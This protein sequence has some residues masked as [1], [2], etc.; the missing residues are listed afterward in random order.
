MGLGLSK[1]LIH[2]LRKFAENDSTI[3]EMPFNCLRCVLSQPQFHEWRASGFG[4]LGVNF[5][6]GDSCP[7]TTCSRGFLLRFVA[8]SETAHCSFANCSVD[9]EV[10][11]NGEDQHEQ[12]LLVAMRSCVSLLQATYIYHVLLRCP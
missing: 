11:G 3:E 6:D 8:T 5:N 10:S 9:G 1:A 4:Q 7:P 2:G 12:N